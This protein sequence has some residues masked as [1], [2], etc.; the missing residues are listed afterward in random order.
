MQIRIRTEYS[1]LKS[2]ITQTEYIQYCRDKDIPLVV[3]E[4]NSIRGLNKLMLNPNASKLAKVL[5]LEIEYKFEH[6][7]AIALNYE[8][9]RYLAKLSSIVNLNEELPPAITSENVIIVPIKTTIKSPCM[10]TDIFDLTIVAAVS[11]EEI[12]YLNEFTRISE[13]EYTE[14]VISLDQVDNT[15]FI[16]SEIFQK[17]EQFSLPT[18][19]G[20][21]SIKKYSSNDFETLTKIVKERLRTVY[22]KLNLVIVERVK[23]ELDT[24]EKLNFSSYFLV[25]YEITRFAEKEAIKI[26]FGRGSAAGSI[27]SYIL[28]ITHVDPIK[29]NLLFERFLNVERGNFPDIDLDIEDDKRDKVIYY[30]SQKY[31]SNFA[32]ILTYTTFGK[33]VVVKDFAKS[34]NLSDNDIM[35]LNLYMTQPANNFGFESKRLTPDMLRII[36][37]VANMPRQTSIHAAGVIIANINLNSRF[38]VFQKNNARLI[39]MDHIDCEKAGLIKF[40]ILGLSN[41]RMID[42]LENRS[43][44]PMKSIPIND[45][46]VMSHFKI[47][48]TDSIFQ[49]ESPGV[50]ETLKKVQPNNISELAI[51]TALYRPGPMENIDQYVKNKRIKY[52]SHRIPELNDILK[53]T[54]G[55]I[56]Y[57]EQVILIF[58]KIAK[59]SLSQ[60]DSVRVAIS[61]KDSQKLKEPIDKLK[62][63][64]TRKYDDTV[65]DNLVNDI[66]KFGEYG[67]NK[68]HA[69]SYAL[70]SYYQM[71]YKV[72]YPHLFEFLTLHNLT[73]TVA[74]EIYTKFSYQKTKIILPNLDN[75]S[76]GLEFENNYLYIGISNIKGI[77][78]KTAQKIVK[79]TQAKNYSSLFDFLYLCK[80]DRDEFLLLAKINFFE[81]FQFNQQTLIDNR[82]QI[83]DLLRFYVPEVQEIS[84]QKIFESKAIDNVTRLKYEV[85]VIGYSPLLKHFKDLHISQIRKITTKNNKSIYYLT[86]LSRFGYIEVFMFEN[87]FIKYNPKVNQMLRWQNNIEIYRGKLRINYK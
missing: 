86:C 72:K 62:L 11:S 69:I 13:F 81:K 18:T 63:E 53:E 34:M 38:G 39:E 3:C 40:D 75:L 22:P 61:K 33:K 37:K 47:A 59:L 80:L 71:Y 4:Y 29:Y 66:L 1:F 16:Q 85:E 6:F 74:P 35:L 83:F 54:S 15:Q 78:M 10:I 79:V 25:V 7:I 21:N 52:G 8:G 73:G 41:L 64:L 51:V 2:L 76:L 87:I 42:N 44:L 68:S 50:K 58:Q 55:I 48:N 45:L 17:I 46:E 77:G 27:L 12:E 28:G 43:G 56:I 32:Q 20:N 67:F 65:I 57:Q 84:R 9:Y 14:K 31:K 70:L 30:L 23:K 24:I 5:A 49:F 82:E 60:A 19:Y 26:G 36:E